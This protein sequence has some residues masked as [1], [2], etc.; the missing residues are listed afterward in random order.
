[1]HCGQQMIMAGAVKGTSHA[2]NLGGL[3]TGFVITIMFLPKFL[4]E[5]L[6]AAAPFTA[7][8]LFVVIFVVLPSAYYES[9]E[10]PV[11]AFY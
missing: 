6:E 4:M 11:C 10:E 8:I 3:I 9:V 7:V 5:D 2:T 1:M